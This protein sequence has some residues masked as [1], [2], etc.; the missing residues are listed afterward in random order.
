MRVRRV[1]RQPHPAVGA[2][3]EAVLAAQRGERQIEHLASRMGGVRP[4]V[5]SPY[6]AD[7]LV[8][9]GRDLVAWYEEL[10]GLER[11]RVRA[12]QEGVDGQAFMPA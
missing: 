6:D 10:A 3:A 11:R 9:Q 4:I 12:E 8:N 2:Q 7:V 5:I 1:L